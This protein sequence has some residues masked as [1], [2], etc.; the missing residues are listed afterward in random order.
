MVISR[1][2]TT[3][4]FNLRLIRG[5]SLTRSV[6]KKLKYATPVFLIF[7]L[8]FQWIQ[9]T[10]LISLHLKHAE[11]YLIIRITYFITWHKISHICESS[12]M[13]AIFINN[14]NCIKEQLYLFRCGYKITFIYDIKIQKLQYLTVWCKEIWIVIAKWVGKH[15]ILL[16]SLVF[17]MR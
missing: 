1:F 11:F 9:K 4:S 16:R 10:D 3:L 12:P 15:S 8:N 2:L 14:Y 7:N 6:F 13:R 17:L 5:E